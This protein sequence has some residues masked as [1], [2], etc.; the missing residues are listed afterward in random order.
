MIIVVHHQLKEA[1]LKGQ[2]TAVMT[3]ENF[4]KDEPISLCTR[5]TSFP[6][7]EYEFATAVARES[8]ILRIFAKEEKIYR[9]VYEMGKWK[10]K[11]LDKVT[12]RRVLLNEGF[13]HPDDFWNNLEKRKNGYIVV[14]QI[15]FDTLQFNN[16]E[17]KISE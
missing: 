8:A 4:I 13:A 14:N 5:T 1:I 15:Y 2:K 3:Q 7:H 17:L 6:A 10:W 11:L 16:S 9:Q 12:T